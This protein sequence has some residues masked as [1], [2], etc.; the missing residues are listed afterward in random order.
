[1]VLEDAH[2]LDPT[3]LELFELVT[4]RIQRLPAL[5]VV[6]SRPEFEPAWTQHGHATTLTLDRLGDGQ[7]AAIIEQTA[8]RALPSEVASAIVTRTDGVPLFVEELTKAVLESG[9]LSDAGDRLELS[10]PLP[11][12]AIPATLHDSLMA[13]LDRLAPVKEV[14]QIG[15]VIGRE[16]SYKLLVAVADRP[17]ARL[18]AALNQLVE[19]EL[20]FRDGTPPRAN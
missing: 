3:T 18:R 19:S 4:E 8:G 10:G 17:E 7:A 13:R 12:L 11:P 15:A 16:F 5:L 6:T 9:L 1:M 20:I 14:A 2:W